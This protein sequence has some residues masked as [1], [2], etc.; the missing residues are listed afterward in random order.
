VTKKLYQIV[1]TPQDILD[2]WEEQLGKYIRFVGLWRAKQ[3]NIW[4]T[5]V[6]LVEESP[7]NPLFEK[8]GEIQF[9][10]SPL[11]QRGARGDSWQL[12][13]SQPFRKSPE[14]MQSKCGYGI[15]DTLK[16]IMTLPWVGTKTAKVVLAVLYGQARIAVDTHVHRVSKRLGRVRGK[17]I[18]ADTTSTRLEKKIPDEYKRKAHRSIIYFWR[19]TCTAKSPQCQTCPFK[20][21]CPEG[22]RRLKE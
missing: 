7:P 2:L 5:A 16:W 3:K 18:S 13:P 20:N 1:K 4:K 12:P 10:D 9:I 11:L 21:W 19:Y 22:K 17:T 14:Q 8:D 15:P 6:I